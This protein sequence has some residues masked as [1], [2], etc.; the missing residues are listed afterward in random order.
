MQSTVMEKW[1]EMHKTKVFTPEFLLIA[2]VE[3]HQLCL[4]PP[5]KKTPQGFL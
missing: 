2:A 5:N 3:I 1:M 4:I